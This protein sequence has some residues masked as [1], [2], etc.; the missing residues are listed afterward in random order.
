[1]VNILSSVAK[2]A[3]KAVSTAVNYGRKIVQNDRVKEA[4]F[5]AFTAYAISFRGP[6][7][8]KSHP[9]MLLA[10]VIRGSIPLVS[11]TNNR[12]LTAGISAGLGLL[13]ADLLLLNRIRYDH[14]HNVSG[15]LYGMLCS[16]FSPLLFAERKDV[17]IRMIV[18]NTAALLVY[19]S[20]TNDWSNSFIDHALP[21]MIHF[22][23][24]YGVT[25]SIIK[26]QPMIQQI[27]NPPVLINHIQHKPL[28]RTET[29]FGA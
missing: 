29:Q 28:P 4:V 1:M 3:C 11:G 21:A 18:M 6:N 10:S 20:L 24:G 8:T 2:T 13:E 17:A 27:L 16:G 12:L 9:V 22:L 25:A 14:H 7:I 15:L 19:K 23:I 26:A 5:S